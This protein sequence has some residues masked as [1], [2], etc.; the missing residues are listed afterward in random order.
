VLLTVVAAVARDVI[1]DCVGGFLIVAENQFA[2]GDWVQTAGQYGEVERVS[3]RRTVLRSMGGDA[4]MIPNGDI[5][6]VVNRTRGWA[7]INLDLGI[8]DARQLQLAR[9][10]IDAA[11]ADLAANPELSSGLIERPQLELLSDITPDGIRLLIWGRVRAAE[12]FTIESE[13]RQ[14][15]LE[16]LAER[17]VEIVSAQRVRIVDEPR[18]ASPA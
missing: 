9:E 17:G 14:R 5:R 10:A 16:A 13:Y 8:A 11:A 7:R 6:T 2:I 3:L 12:R 15:L 4:V 18:R 1:R